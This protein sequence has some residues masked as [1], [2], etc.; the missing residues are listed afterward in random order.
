MFG[1]ACTQV[2]SV[3]Q[4]S[5]R[6]HL[7]VSPSSLKVFVPK[8]PDPVLPIRWQ[9]TVILRD[10][11]GAELL[12][13]TQIPE[14]YQRRIFVPNY[15]IDDAFQSPEITNW[16][17]GR[18]EFVTAILDEIEP[19]KESKSP[20]NMV[21]RGVRLQL[22]SDSLSFALFSSRDVFQIELAQVP[23]ITRS[24]TIWAEKMDTATGKMT[25]FGEAT[26]S[27][28]EWES[29]EKY[30]NRTF[31]R[32][33]MLC[34]RSFSE[35]CDRH[36]LGRLLFHLLFQNQQ[37]L[38][39]RLEA[40]LLRVREQVKQSAGD[41]QDSDDVQ[42]YDVLMSTLKREAAYFSKSA[43]LFDATRYA[44]NHRPIPDHLWN[45]IIILGL[46]LM[47]GLPR[48]GQ[49]NI[50]S[51]HD[52]IEHYPEWAKLLREVQQIGEY[53][54]LELFGFPQRSQDVL[55]VCQ[56]L[57]QELLHTSGGHDAV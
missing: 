38:M 41:R 43:V 28:A 30:L 53:L 1:E 9:F 54:N 6:P 21:C 48:L 40:T 23:G 18:S 49:S 25:V 29:F 3:Y 20:S 12:Q 10:R 5:Q 8:S 35:A 22:L 19:V 50:S 27:I 42:Q 51:D 26:L 37:T 46:Q 52:A 44:E 24:V 32:S 15:E 47:I 56:T 34:F 14:T 31:P 4:E 45:K 7:G 36:S 57:K 17:L 13:D 16:P 33:K 11:Q 55:S 2:V 39:K